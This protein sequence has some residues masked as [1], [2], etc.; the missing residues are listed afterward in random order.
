MRE[1]AG[2]DLL[3]PPLAPPP[4]IPN[5]RSL[6]NGCRHGLGPDA[7]VVGA[8]TGEGPQGVGSLV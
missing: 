5:D 2:E 3:S 7:G 8:A 4:D 6:T 1:P